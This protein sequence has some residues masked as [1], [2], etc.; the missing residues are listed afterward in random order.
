M[1]SLLAKGKRKFNR[2]YLRI[3]GQKDYSLHSGERQTSETMDSI[4]K[5]HILRYNVAIDCIKAN[6]KNDSSLHGLDC[7]SGNG[8][9]CQLLGEKLGGTILG[10]DGSA[11]AIDFANKYYSSSGSFFAYKRFPFVL[12]KESFDYVVSL[13]SI[14]HVEDS[15]EFLDTLLASLKAGGILMLSAPNEAK[16]PFSPD[17]FK[18][19]SGHIIISWD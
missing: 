1:L 3:I 18:F 16:L 9:G 15:V 6:V 14:E 12:P 10:I 11:E 5:D 8:Y 7:F 13:E 4:R 2:I 17:A 19:L